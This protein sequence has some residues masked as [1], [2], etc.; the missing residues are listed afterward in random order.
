MGS[1]LYKEFIR[2]KKVLILTP[3]FM[4]Y[5]VEKQEE[6]SKPECAWSPGGEKDGTVVLTV[7]F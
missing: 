2:T 6:C 4:G 1:L 7:Q 3:L 5:I